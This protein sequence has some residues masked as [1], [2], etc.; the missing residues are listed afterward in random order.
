[1]VYDSLSGALKRGW[2]AYGIQLSEIDNAKSAPYDSAAPPSK[3]FRSVSC[4]R[5]SADGFVYVCDRISD[6]IQVFTKQGQFVKEF[7]VEPVT[8]GLGST[9]A[10]ALSHDPSRDIYWWAMERMA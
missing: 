5:L 7:I 9:W 10:L 4:V 8:R 3:Q 2:G 1:V 6:R